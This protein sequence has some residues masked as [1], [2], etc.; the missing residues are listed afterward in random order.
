MSRT[1]EREELFKALF[2]KIIDSSFKYISKSDYV[3]NMLKGIIENIDNMFQI[4]NTKLKRWNYIEVGVVEKT[5]CY[6]CLYEIMYQK[7][8]CEVAIN[9]SIEIA[10]KYGDKN[11][12]RF[13]NGVMRELLNERE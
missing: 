3:N 6:I 13:L 11:T 10:K 8:P 5:L 9:E 7:L 1:K 12:H 4:F 2:T